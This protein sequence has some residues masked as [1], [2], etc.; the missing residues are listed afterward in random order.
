MRSRSLGVGDRGALPWPL[1][2]REGAQQAEASAKMYD[3]VAQQKEAMVG[4]REAEA[5]KLEVEVQERVAQAEHAARTKIQTERRRER[6]TSRRK[7][8]GIWPPLRNKRRVFGEERQ[9]L[10]NI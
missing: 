1:S 9:P 5:K 3:V 4:D 10:R 7:L 8:D 2:L 6:I